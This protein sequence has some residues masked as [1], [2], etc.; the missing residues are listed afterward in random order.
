MRNL[1]AGLRKG[2][3][4]M[5]YACVALMTL[6]I[7][8]CTSA[9]ERE[10]RTRAAHAAAQAQFLACYES[11]TE[12]VVVNDATSAVSCLPRPPDWPGYT[13]VDEARICKAR[14]ALRF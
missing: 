13:S 6:M 7:L 3:N 14:A 11:A 5:P 1:E 8:A 2:A 4:T 12:Y 9:E 10:R